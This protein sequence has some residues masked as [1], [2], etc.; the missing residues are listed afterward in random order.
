MDHLKAVAS[1]LNEAKRHLDD[2]IDDYFYPSEFIRHVHACL[3]TLRTVTFV[4]QAK[5]SQI[6]NFEPWYAS[7]QQQFAN[8]EYLKWA[9]DERN[10]IE[11]QGD[12]NHHSQCRG[13]IIAGYLDGPETDWTPSNIFQY[14]FEFILSI[15][16]HYKNKHVIDNGI[17]VI[18]RRWVANSFPDRDVLELLAIVYNKIF[19]LV[20]NLFLINNAKIELNKINI[21][22]Y[23]RKT[24]LRRALFVSISDGSVIGVRPD[25]KAISEMDYKSAR[26]RYRKVDFKGVQSAVTFEQKC[27]AHFAQAKQ[28]LRRDGYHAPIILMYRDGVPLP[29]IGPELPDRASK[30]LL[31]RELALAVMEADADTVIFLNEAWGCELSDLPKSGFAADSS[32]RFEFLSLI[33]VEKSGSGLQ[34]SERFLRGKINKRKIRRFL[35]PNVTYGL[36]SLIAFPVLEVWGILTDDLIDRTINTLGDMDID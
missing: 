23:I 25:Y 12:L 1:R 9:K 32:K 4:V 27:Q 16:S 35:G 2:A 6:P 18:E 11:K 19:D 30:Y 5:K 13:R 7:W 33:A 24:S 3:V 36:E 10:K 31:A 20:I 22:L 15:P 17:L 34:I 14:P 21:D 8:D 29:P 28:V 26:R